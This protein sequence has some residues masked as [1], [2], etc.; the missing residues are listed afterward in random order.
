MKFTKINYGKSVTKNLG[1]FNS[2]KIEFSAE[3]E[4]DE[5]MKVADQVASLKLYVNQ[6]LN[7][8]I[9]KYDESVTE[10]KKVTENKGFQSYQPAKKQPK[11]QSKGGNLVD[12]RGVEY[13]ICSNNDGSVYFRITDDSKIDAEHPKSMKNIIE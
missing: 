13:W 12:Y 11:K 4:V 6:L 3:I 5:D 1:D 2:V 7:E 9:N 8:E 10:T